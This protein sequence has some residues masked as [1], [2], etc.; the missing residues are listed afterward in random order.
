MKIKAVVK[1]DENLF[2]KEI[3]ILKGRKRLK[4]RQ[5]PSP[6]GDIYSL[7]L[8]GRRDVMPSFPEI[9][10]ILNAR[11]LDRI[12]TIDG[13]EEISYIG[14]VR[15]LHWY[16]RN[17]TTENLVWG[18]TGLA[19]HGPTLRWYYEVPMD[20]KAFV[21]LLSVYVIRDEVAA[22]E[23]SAASWVE[24]KPYGG[25]SDVILAARLITN[26][27]GDNDRADIGQT[28]TLNA[29]DRI[30]GKTGDD[31]TGGKCRYHV[32]MKATEFDV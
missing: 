27:V 13:I 24:L 19:P 22:P 7:V 26:S 32:V 25:S 16:D 4:I 20:A 1:R 9:F 10:S 8:E 14:K 28:L 12:G 23:G 21:E 3:E 18:P 30:E 15:G 5:T 31:S 2:P 11:R 29:G 17:P 6:K